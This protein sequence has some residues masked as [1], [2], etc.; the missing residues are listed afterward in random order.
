MSDVVIRADCLG[1]R[2][3][4]GG[5][6]ASYR[7]LREALVAAGSSSIRWLRGE[8]QATTPN[9]IWALEDV[10]FEIRHGETVGIIGRNGAGKSTLLKILS[11]ITKPTRGTVD[12]FGRVGSLLEVG[13]G[14]HTELT[15]R[16]NVYLN[17]AILGMSRREIERKFDEIV[18]FADV[19]KFLDTPVK[20][21]SSGMY[22]RL[23]FAVAAHLEPE[24]LVVDEVLAV[25]DAAFQ[26][27]CLGKMGD[28]SK[29]GLTV[30]FVSHNMSAINRL[31][32]RTVLLDAGH[33]IQDGP[34]AMV[35]TAY[36]MGD[37]NAAAVRSWNIENA[38]G[39]DEVRLLGVR[40]LKTDGSSAAIASVQDSLMLRIE[41]LVGQRNTR[42]RCAVMLYTQGVVAFTALEPTEVLREKPGAYYSTVVIPPHLLAEGEYVV[43]VSIFTSAAAKQRFVLVKDAV[44]CHVYDPMVGMSARG[45]YAQEITGVVRPL[46]NWESGRGE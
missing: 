35:T 5:P 34:T 39:T 15:G 40:L 31:C 20:F 12:L 38:P 11:R 33:L 23:A 26:R 46:L 9:I 29:Q 3:R 24:V 41:Y 22:V 42:F 45:D 36:L 13:T 7:T 19:S 10:S 27:K 44:V 30:L 18:D 25:G 8:R 4:I 14:F 1:K 43:G 16:E 37:E 21:Y 17:G 28:V 2:Y 32:A 6:Q